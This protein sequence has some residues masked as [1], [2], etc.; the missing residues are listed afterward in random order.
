MKRKLYTAFC[1]LIITMFSFPY[2]S[3]FSVNAAER[4]VLSE[5]F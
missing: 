4:L 5:P 3:S 1:I 2:M